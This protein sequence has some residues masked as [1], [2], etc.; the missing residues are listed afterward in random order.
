MS[1]WLDMRCDVASTAVTN[2]EIH[3]TNG[4]NGTPC[5]GSTNFWSHDAWK[6]LSVRS[7][8]NLFSFLTPQLEVE[9][10]LFLFFFSLFLALLSIESIVKTPLTKFEK[11]TC[12]HVA[13]SCTDRKQARSFARFTATFVDW[14]KWRHILSQEKQLVLSYRLRACFKN[15]LQ[16]HPHAGTLTGGSLACSSVTSKKN[17]SFF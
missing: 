5:V 12:L 16:Q 1:H 15:S 13:Q 17:S 8:E 7:Q 6:V 3:V 11:H 9:G 2:H 10:S 4:W 14:M